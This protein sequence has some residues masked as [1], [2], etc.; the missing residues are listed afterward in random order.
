MAELVGTIA[1]GISIAT[2][3]VQIGSNIKKLKSYFDELKDAPQKLV[4]LLE[5]LDDLHE[6]LTSVESSHP[7]SS[8]SNLRLASSLTCLSHLEKAAKRLQ[9][10]VDGLSSDFVSSRNLKKLWTANKIVWKKNTIRRY[11]STL[12]ETI[13]LLMLSQQ[14][15]MRF[16]KRH[17]LPLLKNQ[18]QH[19]KEFI[20]NPSPSLGTS[21]TSRLVPVIYKLNITD[22]QKLFT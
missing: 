3:A 7:M 14:L 5:Y 6:I 1:S 8:A 15:Y 4:E 19:L 17:F 18:R 12:K 22:H 16:V 20:Q 21:K 11:K 13:T 2:L 10:L 9:D